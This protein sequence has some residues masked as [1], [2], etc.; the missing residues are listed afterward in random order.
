MPQPAINSENLFQG[1]RQLVAAEVGSNVFSQLPKAHIRI[2][3]P[4]SQRSQLCGV[5]LRSI[6]WNLPPNR[7]SAS[8]DINR[9][10]AFFLVARWPFLLAGCALVSEGGW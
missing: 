3:L 7:F 6:Y 2:Q 10:G 8:T 1:G 5:S 4:E 9:V